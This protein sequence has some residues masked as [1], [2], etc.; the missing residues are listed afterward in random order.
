M[1]G[2][3]APPS[4]YRDALAIGE[5]RAIFVSQVISTLGAV[6][7]E[8]VLT[9]TVYDR[10]RSALLAALVLTLSF[11]PYLFT[12]VFGSSLIDRFPTRAL[13]ISCNLASAVTTALMAVPTI[14]VPG[15]L[16]LAFALGSIAPVFAGARAATLPEVLPAAAFAPGRSLLRIVAQGGQIVGFA[17]GGVLLAVMPPNSALLMTAGCFLG[18]AAVLRVGTRERPCGSMTRP[19]ILRDSLAGLGSV[20]R[21]QPLGG[22]L[23]LGWAV[24]FFAAA[25]EA[26]LIPYARQGGAGG[27]E[28]GLLMAAMPTGFVLGEV[29]VIWYVAPGTQIRLIPLLSL[30]SLVSLLGYSQRPNLTAAAALL[31]LSGMGEPTISD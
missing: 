1:T 24:P 18:S 5:F 15:L 23:T 7:V 4:R 13:L 22:I 19:R 16:V 9:V 25:P 3:S 29:L 2:A 28:T 26:L 31:L 14:P 11:L 12:G 8:I 30:L 6:I 21:T 27:I 20:L 10:S 17:V